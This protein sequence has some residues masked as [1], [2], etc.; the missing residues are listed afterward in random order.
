MTVG[1]RPYDDTGVRNGGWAAKGKA[2]THW[3]STEEEGEVDGRVRSKR[4][5]E[6]GQAAQPDDKELE[7]EEEDGDP[8]PQPVLR[9]PEQLDDLRGGDAR[10]MISYYTRECRAASRVERECWDRVLSE[11]VE[12]EC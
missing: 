9:V 10:E 3:E 7:D 11:S 4:G 6:V 1:R 12:R 5:G 2:L 8:A